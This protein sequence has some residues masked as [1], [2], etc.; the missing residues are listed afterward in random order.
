MATLV[1]P[2]MA[3]AQS[4]KWWQHERF[5]RELALTS[6]QVS[7]LENIYQTA[8]PAMRAQKT[9]LDRLQTD[10]SAL[11]D[12]ARAE[13]PAA[14]DLIARVEAAR[15]DLGR[16]RAVMLYKMRRVLTV[17]QHTKLKVLFAEH[18]RSRK[19]HTRPGSR[20]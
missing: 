6:E 7:R 8:S 14:A 2:A 19:T 18:E 1:S 5:Q 20:R 11:V 17:D 16:T 13:E 9:A 10:L 3:T 12:E 15:A 4:F